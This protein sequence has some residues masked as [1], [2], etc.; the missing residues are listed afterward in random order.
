LNFKKI[1]YYINE[2]KVN[3]EEVH[4]QEIYKWKAFKCFQ[5]NWDV[6]SQ[7]FSFGGEVMYKILTFEDT[8]SNSSYDTK[9][10]SHSVE[11]KFLVRFYL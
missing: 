4:L 10:T 2:Y 9:I 5:D 3:F 11:P 8:E 6:D 7:N 1:E